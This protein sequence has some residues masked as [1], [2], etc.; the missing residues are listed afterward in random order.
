MI[1]DL[2]YTSIMYIMRVRSSVTWGD[3]AVPV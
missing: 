3:F 1:L 2:H